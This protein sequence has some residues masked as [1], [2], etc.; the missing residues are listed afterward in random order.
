M[1]NQNRIKT[2]RILRRNNMNKQIIIGDKDIVF[3]HYNKYEIV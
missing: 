3:T 2:N 1:N